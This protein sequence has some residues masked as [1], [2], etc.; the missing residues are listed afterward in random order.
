MADSPPALCPARPHRSFPMR[1]LNFVGLFL[2]VFLVVGKL[3][4]AGAG[5]DS[6]PGPRDGNKK[7]DANSKSPENLT[8]KEL[9]QQW[10]EL[11]ARREKLMKAVEDIEKRSRTTTDSDG[12]KKIQGEFLKLRAD[13]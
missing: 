3:A 5:Q 13:F 6:Q 7:A 8:P 1:R 12:K 2:L 10:A 4:A 11:V 9:R